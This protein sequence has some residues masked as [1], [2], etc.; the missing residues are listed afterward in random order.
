MLEEVRMQPALLHRV[1]HRT[2]RVRT[3]LVRAGETGPGREVESHVEHPEQLVELHRGHLPRRC[4]PQG[5]TEHLDQVQIVHRL[6]LPVDCSGHLPV[7]VTGCQK[8]G[9][10]HTI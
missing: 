2:G 6:H 10:T 7:R 4:Q 1:V 5:R 8:S 3:A 9:A